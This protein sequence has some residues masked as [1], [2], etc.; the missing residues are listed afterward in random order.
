MKKLCLQ[1]SLFFMISF[2]RSHADK[3]SDD[4]ICLKISWLDLKHK[5]LLPISRIPNKKLR[6]SVPPAK[7]LDNLA[8]IGYF[9]LSRNSNI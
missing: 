8:I 6:G 7:S 1:F 5:H 4:T 3:E 9:L 2:L